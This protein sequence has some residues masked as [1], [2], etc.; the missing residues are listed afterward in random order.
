[1][2][3]LIALDYYLQHKI[4]PA[5]RFLREV[6]KKQRINAYKN[7]NLNHHKYRYAMHNVQ[8]DVQQL[9]A[10]GAI[11][12]KPDLLVVEFSG[13]EMPKVVGVK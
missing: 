11:V 6:D 10:N 4:K 12:S 13:V 1:M 2:T 7:L 3:E 9:L 5:T 8:F